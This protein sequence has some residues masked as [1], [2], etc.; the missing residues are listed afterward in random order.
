[1]AA[2][3][4]GAKPRQAV[5]SGRASTRE[6]RRPRSVSAY[7][8]RLL[9][10]VPVGLILWVPF[11]NKTEPTLAGVPFF[12]WYQLALVLIG[13][14]VVFIVYLLDTRLT[15]VSPRAGAGVDPGAMGDVL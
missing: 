6:A 12:Y 8:P 14:V 3:K 4:K 11:Y 1:M 15:G 2:K 13:A 5:G 10:L 7:W 9:Y